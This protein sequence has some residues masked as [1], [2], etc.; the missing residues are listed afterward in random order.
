MKQFKVTFIKPERI[1]MNKP[2]VIRLAER[3]YKVTGDIKAI[4][5]EPPAGYAVFQITEI[6]KDV[7]QFNHVTPASHDVSNKCD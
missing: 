1:K 3:I 5:I 6:L 7:L 2:Q 4:D